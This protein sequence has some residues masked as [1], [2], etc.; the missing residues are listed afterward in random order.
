MSA[1]FVLS[2]GNR[3]ATSSAGAAPAETEAHS[4]DL[5]LLTRGAL[6]VVYGDIGTSPLYTLREAFGHAGGLHL[7][8]AGVYGVLSLVFWSLISVVTIKYVVLILRA[9]NRGEGGVL[10]L[11]TLAARAVPD[12]P[13]LRGLV[14]VLAL[15]GLALFYGDGLIT[16]AISVLSAVEGLE[17]AAP[18]LQPYVMPLAALV[19]LALFL[20]QSRGTASVGALFGPV[21]L[22]WFA[23]LAVLG[24]IEIVRSPFVLTALDPRWAVGLFHV[25]GWQAFVALGAVVLAVTG[26]EALYADMGHFGPRPIRIAW[27]GLVLPALVVNYFGQGALVLREPAALAHPFYHLAPDW[28]LWPL[29]ALATCATIIASQ[30]VISGVFSLTRQAVRLGHLSRMTIEHT[31]ASE[32]GQVYIPRVNWLL[33]IGVLLLV[34]SFG[35][36]SKLAAAYGISVTGAMA[37]DSVLAGIVAASRWGWGMLPAALVFGG[38]LAI[39]LAYFAANALKIPSGGWLPLALAIGFLCTVA[40][41]RRGREVL[42]KRIYADGQSVKAFLAELDPMLHRAPGTAVFMTGNPHQVP[43]A[44]LH[45][46]RHNNVVHE[47]VVIMHVRVRDEPHVP[48]PQRVLVEKLGKG[49]YRVLAT[50]GFMDDPDVPRALLMCRAHGLPSDPELTSYF[51]AQQTLI[52]SRRPEMNAIEER[53]FV[54]LAAT[55]LSATAYFRMPPDQVV[56]LGMQVEV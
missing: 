47:R 30:A 19:L 23:T 2:G 27:L 52:P 53:L 45:N 16:P 12:R 42:R 3:M 7:S 43:V 38:F 6:G 9:D 24:A 15:V 22:V 54:L 29:I 5:R 13:Q 49:F 11:G 46:L 4:P 44:L 26:A 37:I 20:L 56:E 55:N 40:T 51:L 36:S 31:S 50:Y 48:E 32:I 39:D 14:L 10:A 33:M 8:E 34:V 18:A 17:T 41:W 21:M 25:A 1:G 28:L 35:T